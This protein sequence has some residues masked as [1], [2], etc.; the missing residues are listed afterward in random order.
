MTDK[1]MVSRNASRFQALPAHHRIRPIRTPAYT[2]RCNGKVERHPDAAARVGLQPLLAVLQRPR[3]RAPKL[4]QRLN[5]RRPHS[6][7]GDQPP[8]SSVRNV[9]GQDS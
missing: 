7:L 4:H 8:L 5:R 6:S 2:P 9:R 3:P 1:A